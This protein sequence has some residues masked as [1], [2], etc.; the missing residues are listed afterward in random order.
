VVPPTP[1]LPTGDCECNNER[2][3]GVQRA[4]CR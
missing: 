2:Q 1:S 4:V 3:F